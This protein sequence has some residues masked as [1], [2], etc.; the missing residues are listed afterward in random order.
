MVNMFKKNKINGRWTNKTASHLKTLE[1]NFIL[2]LQ[3][4]WW[5]DPLP[6][7][8]KKSIY[9]LIKEVATI[10]YN[11]GRDYHYDKPFYEP[12][13]SFTVTTTTTKN[14]TEQQINEI[15][16]NIKDFD[17]ETAYEGLESLLKD[18]ETLKNNHLR[19]K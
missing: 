15:K 1:D 3:A 9:E 16:E 18:L 8:M 7:E 19:E 17:Y 10:A 14:P 12:F 5:K 11:D 4:N 2:K 6:K 13:S